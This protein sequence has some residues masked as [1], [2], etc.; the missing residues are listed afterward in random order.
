MSTRTLKRRYA[1][2]AK[3]RKTP[4]LPSDYEACGD[5]GFDHGYEYEQA[6]AWHQKHPGSYE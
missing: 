1:R 4:P 5:C 6:A 3:K 2:R